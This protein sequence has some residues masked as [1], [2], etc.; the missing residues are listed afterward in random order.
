M[1]LGTYANLYAIEEVV[2]IPTTFT[3]KTEMIL[4][5]EK[6]DNNLAFNQDFILKEAIKEPGK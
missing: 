2:S 5:A 4:K 1:V 3:P 6:L